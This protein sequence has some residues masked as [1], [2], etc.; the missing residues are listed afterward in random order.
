MDA[1]RGFSVIS[2]IAFHA[3]YDLVYLA[4]VD[5]PFFHPPFQ[6]IWRASISWTFLVLAGVSCALSHDNLR[7]SMRYLALA[8]AMFVVT[9]IARVD[10]PISFGIIFC[11]GA[12]TLCYAILERLGL[13]PRGPVVAAVLLCAFLLCLDVPSGVVG[14]GSATMPLPRVLYD[15]GLLSW[16]GMPGPGFASGDYYPLIPYTP[17]FMA[18]AS[19]AEGVVAFLRR[20]PMQKLGLGILEFLGRHPLAAYIIHQPAIIAL[21]MLLGLM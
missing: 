13:E 6:D 10:T 18:A 3:C 11:M 1:L 7:R 9:F 17:L 2:M 19:C 14:I 12:S 21:L 15:S 5:I 20:H 16:L 4:G 8:A